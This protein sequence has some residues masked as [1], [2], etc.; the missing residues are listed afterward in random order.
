NT[1]AMRDAFCGGGGWGTF[2]FDDPFYWSPQVLQFGQ[3]KMTY[4]KLRAKRV[5]LRLSGSTT[6]PFTTTGF[7]T[8]TY[9]WN[10]KVVLQRTG[11]KAP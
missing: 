8:D 5:T 9:T 7:G 2:V 4:R 11:R 10:L 6:G 1:Q 3:V